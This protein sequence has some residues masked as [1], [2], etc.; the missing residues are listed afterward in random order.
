MMK[1]Y[2]VLSICLVAGIAHAQ[3]WSDFRGPTQDGHVPAE[4]KL[5]VKWGP[6]TN[7]TWKLQLPGKAWSS[8]SIADGRIYLTN[9]VTANGKIS[10]RTLSIDAKTKKIIWDHEIFSADEE[11]APNIHRKNSHASPTPVVWDKKVYVHFGHQGTAC[12]DLNGKV[13][14]KNN[15]YQYR[16]VHGNGGTPLIVDDVLIFSCDGGNDAFVVGLNRHTGKQIWKAQRNVEVA[17]TFSFTTPQV[18]TV[19]GKKQ[20]IS[21]GSNVVCSY[22]PKTGKEIW[23]VQYDGYSVIPR[24]VYANGL[25]YVCTGYGRP[26]LLAI[27]PT[28]KG[29][30]TNTHVVWKELRSVPNTP[31]ILIVG[32]ELYM[33]S[34]RGI[35][36][37]LDAKTG[38]IHWR[39]RIDGSYSSS[40]IYHKGKIY[41]LSEN[42]VGTVI[43]ATKEKLDVLATNELG[44]R[45]LASYAAAE[46]AL[47]IR[48][49]EHLYR[50][51]AKE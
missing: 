44:E 26:K 11:S 39:E 41:F 31:S 3:D 2:I 30:V 17:R 9:A 19:D 10:L 42:G 18:I 20:V 13:I 40:P 22:E 50:F 8:P 34:D 27:R 23:R 16:P 45:T 14:W 1:K 37:C 12:L 21:P 4:M 28:G 51:E 43:R 29:D 38:K 48:S 25:V 47:F 15:E 49:A 35:A 5:P 6:S 36:S 24:P 7:L 33:V 32:D 46:N